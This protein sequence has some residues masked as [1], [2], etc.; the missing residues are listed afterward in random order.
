MIDRP[1]VKEKGEELSAIQFRSPKNHSQ[2]SSLSLFFF[3]EQNKQCIL[4]FLVCIDMIGRIA[5][6]LARGWRVACS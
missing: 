4:Y 1:R 5:L 6:D 2:S 3:D